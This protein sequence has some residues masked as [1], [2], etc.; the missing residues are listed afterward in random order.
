VSTE[1]SPPRRA[2]VPAL[3]FRWLTGLYDPLIRTW[4]AAA[5]MRAS[6][7]EA[8][9]LQPGMRLLELGAGSGRLAIEIKRAKPE[10]TINA[11]DFDGSMVARSRRNAAKAGVEIEFHEG[12][13][14]R[15]PDLG[16]FDRVYST[17]V[18]HHLSLEAKQEALADARR[19]LRPGGSFVVVDFSRPRD[20][21]QRALFTLIQQPLDGFTNTSPHR[22]GRYEAAVRETFSQV[23][24]AAVWKTA[25][26]TL[27]MFVCGH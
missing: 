8:M 10:V 14:T 3:G 5:R 18:F 4:S 27:E 26:G 16:T 25:A 11:V 22:D 2:F 24:S 13:M 20:L 6:V 7:I 15:L 12:D 21:L 23:R 9:D 19:V 17:M 1:P